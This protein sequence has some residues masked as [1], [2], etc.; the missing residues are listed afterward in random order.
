[1]NEVNNVQ[2]VQDLYAAFGRG[3]IAGIFSTLDEHVDWH[4]NGRPEDIPYAGY[5]QGHAGMGE[6]FTIVGQ[7]CAVQEFGPHEI[8]SMGEHVLSLGH[9]RVLVKAT[10]REFESDWAHVF[11][12][13]NGKIIRLREYYD[14]AALAEAFA[15]S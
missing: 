1:M 5:W 12:I 14:T 6:F 10:G 13:R 8:I 11:T 4:F 15:G 3:D 2:V 7:T 9:E